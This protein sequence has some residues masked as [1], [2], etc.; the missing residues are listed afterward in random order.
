MTMSRNFTIIFAV[1]TMGGL[2]GIIGWGEM[3][4]PASQPQAA[5]NLVA[6]QQL[7]LQPE[8]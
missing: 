3:L 7:R 2:A 6:Q 5:T 1:V 8:R 4:T